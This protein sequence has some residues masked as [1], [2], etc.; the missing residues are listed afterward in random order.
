MR[1]PPCPAAEGWTCPKAFPGGTLFHQLPQETV[2][3][4]HAA[5][6]SRSVNTRFLLQVGGRSSHAGRG[7]GHSEPTPKAGTGGTP[8][9]LLRDD[10]VLQHRPTSSATT[11]SILSCAWPGRGSSILPSPFLAQVNLKHA[12]NAPKCSQGLG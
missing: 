4:N 1:D 11:D 10:C 5:I 3:L 9:E 12:Q 8:S 2:F 7:Q 6:L